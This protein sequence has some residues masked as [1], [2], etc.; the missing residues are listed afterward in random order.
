LNCSSILWPGH[1]LY[2]LFGMTFLSWF[3][4]HRS[5]YSKQFMQIETPL[6]SNLRI[7]LNLKCS[8]SANSVVCFANSLYVVIT[9]NF[10]YKTCFFAE[11]GKGSPFISE[12][13]FF[14]ETFNSLLLIKPF[15]VLWT[16]CS[17]NVCFLV[18][19]SLLRGYP[20]FFLQMYRINVYSANREFVAESLHAS[21]LQEVLRIILQVLVDC[22]YMI[23]YKSPLLIEI[24]V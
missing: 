1:V 16:D 7:F 21:E 11:V 6:L 5:G 23:N 10:C 8:I 13:F 22:R 9:G 2:I 4:A 3:P 18:D 12:T 14:D 15:C 20:F 17:W 24:T 19:C